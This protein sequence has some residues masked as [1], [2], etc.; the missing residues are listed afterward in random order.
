MKGFV[1]KAISQGLSGYKK[2]HLIL[3]PITDRE[4]KGSGSML[5]EKTLQPQSLLIHS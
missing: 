2:A 1:S 4:G 3:L 5:G